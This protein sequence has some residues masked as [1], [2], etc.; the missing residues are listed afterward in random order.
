MYLIKA[1]FKAILGLVLVAS[2]IVLEGLWL[3]FCFGTIVV[4]IVMLIWFTPILFFPFAMV[5]L[6]GW[7]IFNDALQEF[8]PL[9]V[10]K[11]S[12]EISALI[13][14]QI[15]ELE[16]TSNYGAP[17]DDRVLAYV[18]ALSCLVRRRP[19]ISLLDVIDVTSTFYKAPRYKYSVQNLK[20]C[21]DYSDNLVGF[22]EATRG[23]VPIARG[24]L[25]A[26]QGK[27]LLRLA[28]EDQVKR[29]SVM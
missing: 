18:A 16:R 25:A 28:Q 14:P 20:H 12:S 7:R 3:A 6:P 13:R 15:E 9:N 26:G 19:Q 5:S 8:N 23:M 29:T 21:V 24:E 1:I 4:G 10:D 17:L 22:W 11:V 2:G 27:Y